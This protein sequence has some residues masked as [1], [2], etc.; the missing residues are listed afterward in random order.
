MEPQPFRPGRSSFVLV[1]ECDTADLVAVCELVG[2]AIAEAK[3]QGLHIHACDLTLGTK[4]EPQ[5]P[6]GPGTSH[7]T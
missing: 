6:D 3:E 4:M 5:T 7:G 1:V 2:S